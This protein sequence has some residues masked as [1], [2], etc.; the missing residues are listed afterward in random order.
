MKIQ[1]RLTLGIGV[2]FA[3]I[4]LR[5]SRIKSG[6]QFP[7]FIL[8]DRELCFVSIPERRLHPHNRL[9]RN[10]RHPTDPLEVLGNFLFFKAELLCIIKH[11]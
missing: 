6:N 11:L 3:M 8:S 9:H 10:F 1:G 5:S 4:L 7:V 2:L